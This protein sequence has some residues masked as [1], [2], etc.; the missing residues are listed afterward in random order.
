MGTDK[1]VVGDLINFRG[2]VYAPMNENG[3][4]FLFGKV[5]EDLHMYVEEIKPGYPD[6]IARRFTGKGWERVAIEFEF[7][8]SNFQAHKHDP[9]DADMVVCW[10]HDWKTCP[11][12]VV[13]LK[14]LV[15]DLIAAK[16][17][18]PIKRPDA[19]P[20]EVDR[21]AALTALLGNAKANTDVGK[22]L[23][24]LLKGL[25]DL[26]PEIWT[27]IGTKYIGIY[28]PERSFASL[29]PAK[30][31][32]RVDCFTR[33]QPLDGTKVISARLSPRW[34][35]FSIKTDADVE[36]A[37]AVLKECRKRLRDAVKAGELTSYFSG[38]QQ[39]GED[40]PESEGEGA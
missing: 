5:M 26:D 22:W 25:V 29:C 23:E 1:S 6:C 31:V 18:H 9:K 34:S 28:A 38:G 30:T 24:A 35:T 15:Q 10:D 37:L 14:S 8:S 39:T 12:E 27:N 2:M 19:T 13:E 16:K 21:E 3:V 33:G 32:L 11:L 7:R 4:V 17:N 40:G 36:K 20:G